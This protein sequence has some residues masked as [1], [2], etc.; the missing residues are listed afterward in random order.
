MPLSYPYNICQQRLL[1]EE[2]SNKHKVVW[3]FVFNLTS[4]KNDLNC[5]WNIIDFVHITTVFLTSKNN[6]IQKVWKVQGKRI[7][8]TSHVL[9]K[10][11]L[12]FSNHSLAEHQKSL[13]SR[14]LNFAILPKNINYADYLLPLKLLFR[15][16][17]LC[18]IPS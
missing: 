17:D 2:I 12:N 4:L 10:V 1:N 14:G 18:E 7:S 8:V 15:D 13:L 16:N 9:E 6:N 5:V 3:T 11:L